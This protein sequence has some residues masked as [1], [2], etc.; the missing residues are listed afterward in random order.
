M[1]RTNRYANWLGALCLLLQAG[2]L[3]ADSAPADRAGYER[4]SADS[5]LTLPDVLAY[6]GAMAPS[7]RAADAAFESGSEATGYVAAWAA[8]TS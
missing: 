2:G 4:P 3:R 7:V 8:C 6:A 1:N 5:A